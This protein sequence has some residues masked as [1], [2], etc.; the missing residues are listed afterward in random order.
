MPI[1]S[2][3]EAALLGLLSERP[4][5]A[6]EIEKIIEERNM[7]YW[8]EISFST[9]YYELKKLQEKKLVSSE[10]KLSENN[11]AKK[12]YTINSNGKKIMKE[13]V[14]ELLSHIERIVWQIDLGMANISLLDEDETINA[15]T[16]YIDSIE[17]YNNVYL[18]LLDFM[19]KKN[20][21]DSDMAMAE[22]P[23][24]HL[25]AEKRWAEEYLKGVKNGT[26]TNWK[27]KDKKQ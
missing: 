6:Y 17:K 26:K 24:M 9:L 4:M 8:T 19:K 18:G 27:N 10:I 23:I 25:E 16:E 22:R 20:Y 2:N 7:R 21:P 15:F 11:I 3:R 14:Y 12:I 1:I 5:Y 13:K